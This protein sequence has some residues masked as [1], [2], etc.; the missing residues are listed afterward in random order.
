MDRLPMWLAATVLLAAP[1]HAQLM[2]EKAPGSAQRAAYWAAKGYTFSPYNMTPAE[3]DAA[4]AAA[5]ARQAQIS[6]NRSAWQADQ[7]RRR[8]AYWAQHGYRFDPTR[9]STWEM[10]AHVKKA[11]QV[12][13]EQQE[14]L[15]AVEA[16]EQATTQA[17][18]THPPSISNKSNIPLKPGWK[19]SIAMVKGRLYDLEGYIVRMNIHPT[20]H[21][22]QTPDGRWVVSITD[23]TVQES[24]PLYLSAQAH[25]FIRSAMGGKTV[26]LYVRVGKTTLSNQYGKAVEGPYFEAVG[27]TRVR[28]NHDHVIGVRW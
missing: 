21:P 17:E 23:A 25:P 16:A 11:E 8:A 27:S 14:R 6:R 1:M 19:Y 18:S 10:D 12:K 15:A 13:R 28:D 9:M 22:K 24:Y 5:H 2:S 4:A 7:A 20:E 3:M 26:A